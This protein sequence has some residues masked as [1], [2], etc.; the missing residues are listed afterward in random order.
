MAGMPGTATVS[1]TTTPWSLDCPQGLRGFRAWG[2]GFRVQGSGFRVQ[3][4]GFR[5]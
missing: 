5:V 4:S 1:M 2:L 3:G